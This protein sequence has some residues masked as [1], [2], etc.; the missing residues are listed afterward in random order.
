MRRPFLAVLNL[1]NKTVF[2]STTIMKTP[3]GRYSFV[4]RVHEALCDK[5]YETLADAKIA[6]V[7]CMLD[8]GETFPV[9]L[10]PNAST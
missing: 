5:S 9:A 10:S 8:T 6:A 4:G 3:N 7:D 2:K 1:R